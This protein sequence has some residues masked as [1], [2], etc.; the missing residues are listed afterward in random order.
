MLVITELTHRPLQETAN[1]KFGK[2]QKI[3]SVF[4]IIYRRKNIYSQIKGYKV[5]I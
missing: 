2:K 4:N 3:R 5:S 1:V